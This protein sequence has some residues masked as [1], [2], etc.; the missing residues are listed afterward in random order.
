MDALYPRY[1]A[2]LRAGDTVVLETGS[3]SS[4]MTPMTLPDGVRVEAQVLWGSIGWA[5]PA[6]FGVALAD[7]DRRT[8]LITGEGS[9]QLTANDIGAMGRFGANVIVFVLNNSGYL[10]E[11][12]AGRKPE[13]DLQRSRALELRRTAEGARMLGLVH[14]AGDHPWRAR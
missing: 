4:G 10:I 13:L 1:A 12:V 3:T 5:T 11:R 6:A 14:G 2:F 9:H 7:P 8:V